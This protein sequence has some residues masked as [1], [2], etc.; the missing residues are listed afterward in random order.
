MKSIFLS[1]TF[2]LNVLGIA[3]SVGGILPVKYGVPIMS[4]VNIGMRLVTS[5][6]VS[7]LPQP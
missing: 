1:R 4:V 3:A 6:P 2:W 7:V 5:K